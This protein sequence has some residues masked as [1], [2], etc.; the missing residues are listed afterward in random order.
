VEGVGVGAAW[1]LAWAWVVGNVAHL[2]VEG[3]GRVVEETRLAKEVEEVTWQVE[4]EM[5]WVMEVVVG[6]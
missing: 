1:L 5:A 2:Q 6:I 4:V 3:I